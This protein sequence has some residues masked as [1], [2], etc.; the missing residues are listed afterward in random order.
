M[1]IFKSPLASC[2]LLLRVAALSFGVWDLQDSFHFGMARNLSSKTST[3]TL[4]DG[5]KIPIFGLGV[6]LAQ[7]DGETEQ[8][9]LWALKHGYRLIDTAAAYKLVVGSSWI[10]AP[11]IFNEVSIIACTVLSSTS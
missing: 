2:T 10:H 6:Y 9:V 7:T 5:N 1:Q 8:A 11:P 3:Y 4:N